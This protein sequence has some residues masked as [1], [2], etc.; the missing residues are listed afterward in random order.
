MGNFEAVREGHVKGYNS[1]LWFFVGGK[2]KIAIM[3]CLVELR[4]RGP[5]IHCVCFTFFLLD[6]GKVALL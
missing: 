5:L 4:R 3:S 2:R 1:G 6:N